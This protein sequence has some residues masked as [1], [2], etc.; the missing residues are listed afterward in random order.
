M[1]N[2]DFHHKIWVLFL[3]IISYWCQ[4]L[5]ENDI[6]L[7]WYYWPSHIYFKFVRKGSL[8]GFKKSYF[9]ENESLRS[10]INASTR[11]WAGYTTELIPRSYSRS[12]FDAYI[13]TERSLKPR[14]ICG[15]TNFI[16]HT[17]GAAV[18]Y[19]VP[20]YLKICIMTP[21]HVYMYTR[22]G[23]HPSCYPSNPLWTLPHRPHKTC[24]FT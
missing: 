11:S 23:F 16:F 24:M 21:W 18:R 8:A 4:I 14:N 5:K 1:R 9:L 19:I 20:S 12:L 15:N 6:L 17:P 7:L 13:Q 2:I 10:G 3:I 22:W